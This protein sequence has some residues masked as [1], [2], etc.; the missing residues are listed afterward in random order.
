MTNTEVL[1]Q[2]AVLPLKEVLKIMKLHV[3]LCHNESVLLSN[4]GAGVWRFVF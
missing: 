1:P 3:I 4:E 2:S